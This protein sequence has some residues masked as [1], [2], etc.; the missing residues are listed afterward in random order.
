VLQR[1]AACCSVLQRVAACCS[2]LQRVALLSVI[3][4][5]KRVLN[6][7]QRAPQ[8]MKKDSHPMEKAL[9]LGKT[10]LHVAVRETVRGKGRV[11]GARD[12]GR[13]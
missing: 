9:Y 8:P 2:V 1:V 10:G 3:Y 11:S 7:M 5:I 6:Q 13:E 12:S 4:P